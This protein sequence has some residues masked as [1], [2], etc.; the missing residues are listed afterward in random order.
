MNRAR[1]DPGNNCPMRS[2]RIT[3]MTGKAI[4]RIETIEF[5]HELVPRHLGDDGGGGNGEAE[6]IPLDYC[7]LRD[8]QRNGERTVNEE[9][10]GS[11]RQ[12]RHCSPHGF[13][14]SP[15]DVH[16]VDLIVVADTDADS[17]GL[18][19]DNR[20]ESLPLPLRQLLGVGDA[21]DCLPWMKYHGGR[22]HRSGQGAATG[23]V[24]SGYGPVT[25]LVGIILIAEQVSHKMRLFRKGRGKVDLKIRKDAH[26]RHVAIHK[27]LWSAIPPVL[28]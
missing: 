3:L 22:H 17:A 8:L 16:P 6:G 7:Q 18:G 24:G 13:Q 1:T 11:N 10:I 21:G 25:G 5:N 14:R 26:W 20:V 19:H 23:L 2:G 15:K 4:T 12:S 9:I 28:A 27:D